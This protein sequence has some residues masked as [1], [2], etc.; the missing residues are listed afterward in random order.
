MKNKI[1]KIAKYFVLSPLY[2]LKLVFWPLYLIFS[3]LCF[4]DF[5]SFYQGAVLDYW[6]LNKK[7]S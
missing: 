4:S 1:Y 5:D 6:W 2:I 7:T 3:F